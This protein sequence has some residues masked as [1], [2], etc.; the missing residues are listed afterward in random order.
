MVREIVDME[1]KY[2]IAAAILLMVLA[3]GA[4]MKYS[5][6]RQESQQ[7]QSIILEES[8]A[9][10]DVEKEAEMIQ[11]YVIG[12][13]TTPGVYKLPVESRVLEAVQMAQ[14]LPEAD[15]NSINLAQK[16]DDGDAIVVPK[17][18]DV[19]A[20]NTVQGTVAWGGI[21]G[22]GSSGKVN[23]NSSSAQELD[24]R[25][26]GIGPAIAQRIVDYRALHGRFASI[27]ELKEVSGIGDKKYADLQDLITV[28]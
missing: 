24:Q 1:N 26:P 23:I 18:G 13:V 8:Q 7:P 5:H 2:L 11:V 15:L 9:K 16:M 10:P 19:P 21:S 12:A 3:F 6:Y 27:E 14:A 22:P 4:G 20:A 17:T 28:K 25:L